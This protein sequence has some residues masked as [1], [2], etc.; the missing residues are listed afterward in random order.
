MNLIKVD[1]VDQ[2]D[3]VGPGLTSISRQQTS[4]SLGKF[5][6]TFEEN[7]TKPFRGRFL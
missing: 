4:N 7:A 3:K 2:I 1:K 5:G 6:K